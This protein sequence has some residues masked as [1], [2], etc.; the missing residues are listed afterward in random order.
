MLF[1][2]DCS[3]IFNV[4]SNART[5]FSTA[6]EIISYAEY[7]IKSGIVRGIR[8]EIVCLVRKSY[9]AYDVKIV[10]RNYNRMR[11]TIF[12]SYAAYD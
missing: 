5:I 6:Y 3:G 2:M 9:A 1:Y 4:G 12:F 8:S 10:R 11:H 7:E